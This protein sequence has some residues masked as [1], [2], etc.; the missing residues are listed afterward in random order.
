MFGTLT[1]LAVLF[2]IGY[3]VF[4]LIAEVVYAR[5]MRRLERDMQYQLTRV[6][7]RPRRAAH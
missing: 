3:F 1:A 5:R 6:E 7:F 2:A 4:A